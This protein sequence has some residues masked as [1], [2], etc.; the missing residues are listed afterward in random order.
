MYEKWLLGSLMRGGP[1]TEWSASGSLT[2]LL[3]FILRMRMRLP[4]SDMI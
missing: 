1:L 4:F 2:V 3:L